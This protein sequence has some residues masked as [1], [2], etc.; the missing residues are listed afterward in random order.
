M[1]RNN[2]I[3]EQIK[4]AFELRELQPSDTAWERMEEMLGEPK[5]RRNLKPFW[6]LAAACLVGFLLLTPWIFSDT[7]EVSNDAL[8]EE[9]NASPEEQKLQPIAPIEIVSEKEEIQPET[10]L[11][12]VEKQSNRKRPEKASSPIKKTAIQNNTT[13]KTEATIAKVES[14]E[15]TQKI[16]P[17]NP[18]DK[19]IQETAKKVQALAEA[20]PS[21]TADDIDKL[22]TEAQ[23][24]L[25]TQRILDANTQKV[26]AAA[27][28]L[29]V[30]LELERSFREKV[31][32][33]LGDGFQ[34]IRTAMAERN[35]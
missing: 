19:K 4:T 30:E 11:A 18:M 8:V 1:E 14:K 20:N 2:N 23:A 28:L 13:D 34:K 16:T 21:I 32:D 24:E 9:N 12:E 35:N 29:D 7:N 17:E 15:E 5:K 26:D 10:Q 6:Y 22:L 33:A 3:E 25:A 31:F 27:L